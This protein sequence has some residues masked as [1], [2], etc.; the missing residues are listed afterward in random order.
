MPLFASSF[1]SSL[2]LPTKSSFLSLFIVHIIRKNYI[3]AILLERTKKLI[4]V[5][6]DYYEGFVYS[7]VGLYKLL[8]AKIVNHNRLRQLLYFNNRNR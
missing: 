7:T 1:I 6:F 3:L 2:S 4:I 8:L 5:K